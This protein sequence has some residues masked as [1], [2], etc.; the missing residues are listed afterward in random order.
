MARDA[1]RGRLVVIGDSDFATDA[2]LD[3]LGNRDIALNAVAWAGGEEVL[4]GERPKD[5]PEVQRPLSP[6]VLTEAQARRLLATV[7]GVLPGLVLLDRPRRGD[8]PAT[9]GVISA[10]H[11]APAAARAVAAALVMVVEAPRRL[12][13]P[14]SVRGPRVLRVRAGAVRGLEIEAGPRRLSAV[15][16]AGGWLLDGRP[17]TAAAADAL[18]TLVV[19]LA[20]LRAVDAFR[21]ADRQ[22]L[23]L[24]PPAAI[25]TLKTRR[26]DQRLRLGTL[27]AAGSALYAERA[28]HPRAFLAGTGLLSA[29][30][31]VFY[32]HD[33]GGRSDAPDPEAWVPP[34]PRGSAG[35]GARAEGRDALLRSRRAALAQHVVQDLGPHAVER[36]GL[37]GNALV[38]PDEV[39][40]VARS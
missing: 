5:A 25:I 36:R 34:S 2:Y 38:D 28:G 16:S 14:E 26:G 15:R 32:Q 6:L 7:A 13:G 27:N 11:A 19:T 33:L 37:G 39:Q 8:D 23:G 22:A 17:A 3:L 4:A 35:S 21:P 20:S 29:L 40:P 31:R 1:P 30:E 9:R 18:D 12:S 10:A 24:E